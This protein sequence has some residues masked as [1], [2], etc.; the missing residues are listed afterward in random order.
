MKSILPRASASVIRGWKSATYPLQC[1][2]IRLTTLLSHPVL[3]AL[4]LVFSYF[5]CTS[6]VSPGCSSRNRTKRSSRCESMKGES[7]WRPE[8]PGA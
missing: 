6:T 3:L 4:V 1:E 5:M 7:S 8:L 2:L